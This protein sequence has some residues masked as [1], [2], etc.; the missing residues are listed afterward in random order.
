MGPHGGPRLSRLVARR[1]SAFKPFTSTTP[2]FDQEVL[3]DSPMGYWRLGDDVTTGVA[4]AAAG[5]VNGV[6]GATHSTGSD[7]VGPGSAASFLS[8]RTAPNLDGVND[9][10]SIPSP[11]APFVQGSSRTYEA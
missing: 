2:T 9:F 3:A 7:A 5:T 1:G 6:Y 8:G 4:K 11:F 10:I